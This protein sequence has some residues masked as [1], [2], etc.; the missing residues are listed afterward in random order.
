VPLRCPNPQFPPR[1]P[2]LSPPFPCPSP[3]TLLF[4][5]SCQRD[6][7]TVGPS[8][9]STH[10]LLWRG[11]CPLLLLPP[12]CLF[13]LSVKF[14]DGREFFVCMPLLPSFLAVSLESVMALFSSPRCLSAL[15]LFFRCRLLFPGSRRFSTPIVRGRSFARDK[16]LAGSKLLLSAGSFFYSV[17]ASVRRPR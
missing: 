14:S 8:M 11:F 15:P 2:P 3:P 7:F 10:F 17:S 4:F 6:G 16:T 5:C 1:P 12:F 13:L 9:A